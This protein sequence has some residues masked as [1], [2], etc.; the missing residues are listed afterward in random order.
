MPVKVMQDQVRPW[1]GAKLSA[2]IFMSVL[3]LVTKLNT[4][5]GLSLGTWFGEVC[6]C[7]CLLFCLNLPKKFWHPDDHFLAHPCL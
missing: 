3:V 1:G 4:E 6:S 5:I 7:C 2:S